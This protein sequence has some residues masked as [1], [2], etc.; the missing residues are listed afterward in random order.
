LLSEIELGSPISGTATPANGVV[1][2]TTMNRLYAVNAAG[3]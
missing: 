2:V 1:Y 3:R